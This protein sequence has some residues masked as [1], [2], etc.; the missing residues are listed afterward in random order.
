MDIDK[1][2]RELLNEFVRV[3]KRMKRLDK[4]SDE[5]SNHM[6]RLDILSE[7]AIRFLQ[8]KRMVDKI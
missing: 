4:H 7:D 1:K 5:F 2:L 3:F 8:I 6:N